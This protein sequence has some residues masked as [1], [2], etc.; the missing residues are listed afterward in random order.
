MSTNYDPTDLRGQETEQKETAAR[1]RVARDLEIADVKW[2]MSTERGRRIL[3][4]ILDRAGVFRISFHTNAMQMAFNE[5]N[6]NLGNWLFNEVM[7]LCPEKYPVM[8]EEQ[9]HGERERDNGPKPK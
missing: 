3:W 7:Q 8:L 1:N 5:G 9:K 4:R 2:L 6:R